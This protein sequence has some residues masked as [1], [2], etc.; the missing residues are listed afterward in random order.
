MKTSL[1][2]DCGMVDSILNN[3]ELKKKMDEA[4]KKLR[5]EMK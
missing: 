5:K 2:N 3:G 4:V 1:A